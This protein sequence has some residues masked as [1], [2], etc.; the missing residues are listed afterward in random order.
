[1]ANRYV[2][3]AISRQTQAIA[4]QGFGVPLILS[5]DK[6]A[7]Y[8]EYTDLPGVAADFGSGSNTYKLATALLAQSPKVAKFAIVGVLATEGTTPVT[9]ITAKLDTT[10]LT[11]DA[12]YYLLCTGQADATIVALSAWNEANKKFY[13]AS[14]SNKSLAGTLNAERTVILV[15]PTPS[16]YPAAA[17]VGVGAPREIGS[18]T[19]T[20]KTLNGV[21][22]SGYSTTDIT[23]IENGR[24]S[25]Y[26]KEGGVN[27]TSRGVTTSGEY[28]DIIQGQDYIT[29][30]MTEAV[31]NLLINEDKV[32]YTPQGIAM[33]VAALEGA[34]KEAHDMGIV[35]EDADGKPLF[36]VD[37]PSINDI[38]D[39]NKAARVLP[40]MTWG[41]TI[42]GA[43][44]DVDINGVLTL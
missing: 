19:W 34:L 30:R 7:A 24:A 40:N 26:I 9:T 1:L 37:A 32:P 16:Q 43:V 5:L 39:A 14:T 3:V 22:P 42:A 38:S 25:T 18:F 36:S 21:D 6:D 33:V 35:S 8:K 11:Y 20:F 41:A 4:Q 29:A 13:F 23:T 31:F 17:W 15:H 44:E 2:S 10:R 28:I 27:I 12:W